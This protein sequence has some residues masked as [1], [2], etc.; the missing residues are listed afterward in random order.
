MTKTQEHKIVIWAFLLVAIAIIIWLLF[1]Q[2]AATPAAAST[3]S[4]TLTPGAYGPGVAAAATPNLNQQSTQGLPAPLQ[5]TVPAVN[6]PYSMS[7]G[8][9]SCGCGDSV[10]VPAL[11]NSTSTFYALEQQADAALAA[12]DAA[13]LSSF[14]YTMGVAVNNNTPLGF[15]ATG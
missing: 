4:P 7:G 5:F 1:D 15:P 3:T 6:M 14:G 10:T 13:V 9:C 11:A 12:S 2:G 8:D